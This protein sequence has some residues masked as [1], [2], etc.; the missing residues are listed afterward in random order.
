MTE[1]DIK[2]LRNKKENWIVE[3]KVTGPKYSIYMSNFFK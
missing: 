1:R 2:L 3:D